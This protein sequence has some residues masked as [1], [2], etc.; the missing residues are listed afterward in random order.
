MTEI[1]TDDDR[2]RRALI[3]AL[4]L[5]VIAAYVLFLRL[6]LIDDAHIA[7]CYARTLAT[8]GTWGMYPGHC[9]NVATSPLNVMALAAVGGVVR[10]YPLAAEIVAILSFWT[11]FL[12]ASSIGRTLFGSPALGVVTLVAVATNPSVL[13]A[14]GLEGP[15]VA[16][17]MTATMWAVVHERWRLG[18]AFLGLAVLARMDA[19]LLAAIV[20]T[21]CA[22][23]GAPWRRIVGAY[24]V[25][26]LPWFLFSWVALGSFVPDTY[27]LKTNQR[28]GDDMRF[29]DGPALYFRTFPLA[30]VA[31]VLLL[32][33]APF[34]FFGAPA[35]RR[36]AWTLTAYAAAVFVAYALLGPPPCPWY[37][38]Q[39]VIPI[40]VVGA[41]GI[42]EAARRFGRA[43][44]VVGVAPAAALAYA[45][46]TRPFPLDEQF[47]NVNWGTPARYAEIG[48]AI[49]AA[50]K[51]GEAIQASCESGAFAYCSE[52]YLVNEF[53][54]QARTDRVIDRADYAGRRW[55]TWLFAFNF[56]WR[57]TKAPAPV[58]W[59]LTHVVMDDDTTVSTSNLEWDSWTRWRRHAR[60]ILT[61]VR[62]GEF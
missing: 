8:S 42:A 1:R 11:V 5:A 9:A 46:T 16:A 18:G 62:P 7:M 59:R 24:L 39:E 21:T 3:P 30:S 25:A 52:R 10:S 19:L 23:S 55:A 27:F 44:L 40:A 51:P 45:L 36:I 13:A 53:S 37:F 54:D 58:R 4:A 38:L 15:L 49:A 43:A 2:T 22:L 28:W 61:P 26:T 57:G 17:L 20:T 33:C 31:S 35:V 41:L 47:I 48:R 60:L 14:V 34:A 29:V 6:P 12:C 56:A 50:T 32:P